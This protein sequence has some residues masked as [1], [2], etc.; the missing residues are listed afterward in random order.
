M[1]DR[2]LPGSVR[3]IMTKDFMVLRRDL[4][5]MSQLVTP[6]IFGIIYAFL[7]IRSGCE[8]PA[9]RG[10]AP[11]FVMELLSNLMVYANVG[12]SMFVGIS[13]VSRLAGVGFSQEGKQFWLLKS[14]PVSTRH[15]LIAKYLVAYLPTLVLCLGFLAIISLLQNVSSVVFIFSL[16]VIMLSMAG[17]AAMN[18]AFGV[19]GANFDWEDPRRMARGSIGCLGVLASFAF[20]CVC[21]VLFFGPM[22]II[23]ALG[24][25]QMIGQWIGLLLGGIFCLAAGFIPVWAVRQRVPYLDET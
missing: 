15:M 8:T 18:L 1:L 16:L 7:L 24:G 23:V 2:L 10:E 19:I 17:L 6:L 9:G 21:L 5:N 25:A 3:G 14:A 4:R 11:P 20:L 13:L 12:I 22:L